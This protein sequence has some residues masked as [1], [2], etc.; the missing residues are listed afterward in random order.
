MDD[1]IVI[2]QRIYLEMLRQLQDYLKDLEESWPYPER[3]LQEQI[4]KVRDLVG[5]AEQELMEAPPAP[6]E[7]EAGV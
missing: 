2:R 1:Q 7:K 5:R 4:D 6:E 3:G